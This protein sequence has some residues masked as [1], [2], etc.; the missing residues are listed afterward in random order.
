MLNF[1]DPLHGDSY[2]FWSG[3][4]G[5]ILPLWIASML[6]LAPTRCQQLGCRRKA[7]ELHPEN[8]KPMCGRH[9]P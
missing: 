5:A 9:M 2:Q 4:G 7:I 1:L 8:G 3:V 6:Y